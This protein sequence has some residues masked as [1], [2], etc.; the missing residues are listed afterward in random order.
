MPQICGRMPNCCLADVP[1]R[2]REEAEPVVAHADHGLAADRPQDEGEQQQDQPDA[3]LGEAAER[4][5]GEVVPASMG[6]PETDA[7][8]RS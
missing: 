1:R 5:V 6:G 8:P 3:G 7:G 2:G 4:A